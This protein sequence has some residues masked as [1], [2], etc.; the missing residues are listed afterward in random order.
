MGSSML[1]ALWS[2]KL[3]GGVRKEGRADVET[4][5]YC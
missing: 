3:E 1:E 4:S 5:G 2:T